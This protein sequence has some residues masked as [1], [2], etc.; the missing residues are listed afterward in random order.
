LIDIEQIQVPVW[1]WRYSYEKDIEIVHLVKRLENDTAFHLYGFAIDKCYS[2]QPDSSFSVE[3]KRFN[4]LDSDIVKYNLMDT[5]T[6]AH[7][8]IKTIFVHL[9]V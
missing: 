5:F 3:E 2:V 8:T 6:E 1:V 7:E 9:S 4:K